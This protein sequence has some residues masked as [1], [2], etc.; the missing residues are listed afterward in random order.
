MKYP[1][2]IIFIILV[3]AI[4]SA[5]GNSSVTATS[6][7]GPAVKPM[8]QTQA[9]STASPASD[10]LVYNNVPLKPFNHPS[11]Q[12][13]IMYPD[14]WQLFEQP[15]G[16]IFVDPTVRAAYGVLFSL[17]DTALT[18]E[19]LNAF[20]DQFVRSAFGHESGFEILSLDKN[21]IRFKSD[22]SNLGAS[23]TEITV[24]QQDQV[25]YF[26]QVMVAEAL[27]EQSAEQV[28]ALMRGLE[29]YQT[30]AQPA[31]TPTPEGPPV[32]LLYAHPSQRI[33][34]LY[35]DSWQITETDL[36]VEAVQPEDAFRF[37]A[38]FLPAVGAGDSLSMVE[39]HIRAQADTLAAQF[40]DFESLPITPYQ[41]GQT[42]GYT[43]D[44]LYTSELGIPTAGSMI[45]VGVEDTIYHIVITAPAQ[46]Y[47]IALNWFNP[48][49]QSFQIL[50]EE[51]LSP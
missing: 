47:A 41:V 30:Q 11:G 4:L 23:V 40:D 33:A 6:A 38:Q 8:A 50:H 17:A 31:A 32:W 21:T 19:D 13:S 5:C 44:Y 10:T 7:A 37:S 20:A 34:F 16:V 15:N 45:T 9:T 28:R 18:L 48:I 12:F 36:S 1:G 42:T 26:T 14:N 22:D 3:L 43:I 29:I 49:M 39:A 24:S 51:N 46:T 25:I 27:W 35:P 2:F